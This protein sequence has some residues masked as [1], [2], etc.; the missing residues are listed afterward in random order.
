MSFYGIQSYLECHIAR[1][2]DD[3]LNET[4]ASTFIDQ[5]YHGATAI[6]GIERE[7]HAPRRGGRKTAIC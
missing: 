3:G 5:D 7:R 1:L 2:D 4:L 6:Y